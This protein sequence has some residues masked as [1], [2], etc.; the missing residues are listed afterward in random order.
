MV[1]S[2]DFLFR[3]ATLL[4]F[5]GWWCYWLITEREAE[6]EKPKTMVP[7]IVRMQQQFQRWLLRLGQV[8]VVLQLLGLSLAVFPGKPF[9][10]QLIGLII[11]IVGVGISIS[12]RK[13]LGSNWSH[14]VEYQVKKKQELVTTGI[15][16]VIRHP[17]YAGL[18]LAIIGG[19][20]VA[21]SY[22]VFF[23]MALLGIGYW[24]AKKEEALLLT[25]F[26]NAYKS[27]MKR[28]KMFLPYL[29]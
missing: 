24:Q 20:L 12:A 29:W 13:T 26:G 14:A 16:S 15:Y 11:V 23:G 7:D 2:L 9:V 6:K 5:L 4:I 27:Y 22:G 21:Q 1:L 10:S 3:V 18:C 17:I 25:H 19:E 8:V 28:T